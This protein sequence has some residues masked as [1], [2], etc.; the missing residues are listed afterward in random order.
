[1]DE[2]NPNISQVIFFGRE[3]DSFFLSIVR[4]RLLSNGDVSVN[5]GA[6]VVSSN[7]L[8]AGHINEIRDTLQSKNVWNKG[9]FKTITSLINIGSAAHP[10]SVGGPIDLIKVTKRKTIWV[11]RKE[12]C[13]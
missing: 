9:T 3:S 1:M 4:F 13:Q 12:I 7:Q 10:I 6:S 11:Q 2:N 8:Y 5:L